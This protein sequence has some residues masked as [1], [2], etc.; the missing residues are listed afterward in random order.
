MRRTLRTS[1]VAIACALCTGALADEPA[2]VVEGQQ[3]GGLAAALSR[4]PLEEERLAQLRGRLATP[5]DL[6]QAGVVLWDEPRK[7]LPPP[8]NGAEAS[9][10]VNVTTSFTIHRTP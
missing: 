10:S 6:Q 7:G 2:G 8:R 1:L 3:P 9:A 4:E 5:T